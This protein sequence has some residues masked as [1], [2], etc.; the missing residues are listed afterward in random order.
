MGNRIFVGVV[1]LLWAGTMSWLMVARILPPFFQGEPPSHGR[2]VR[3]EPICWQIEYQGQPIGYAVSQAVA[4]ALETTEIYSR[5]MLERIGIRDLAPQWMGSLVRGIGEISVDSRTR[6]VLDSLRNLSSFETKIRLNDMPLVM[7]V[8]GRVEGPELRMKIQSGE[9][10]HEMSYPVPSSA[11]LA[12]ELMPEPK[13]LQVYVGRKWQQEMFSPFRPPT[14]SMEIVQAEVVEEGTIE[15]RG[16]SVHARTIEYRSLTAAGVS[17]DNTLRAV[18]WVA[19]DGMVLRQD[20]YLMN[21]KLR[22]VRCTERPMIDLA[23][24][25]LDLETVATL[26]PPPK[27]P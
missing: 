11:M 25:L 4:G 2:P 21:A 8:V 13:L 17:A 1:I 6:L 18:V 19:D 20:V 24:K 22:F 27:S 14:S 5:V 12:N 16:E 26:A 23:N 9:I 10:T 7:R 3:D 15:H